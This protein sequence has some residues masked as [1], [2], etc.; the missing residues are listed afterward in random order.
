MAGL[1]CIE[2]PV[3]TPMAATGGN[4]SGGSGSGGA[5]GG[6]VSGG[7]P[8]VAGSA[9]LCAGKPLPPSPLSLLTRGQYE[10]TIF[11][12]LTD[13]SKPAS[14][15]PPENQVQGFKN[16]TTAHQASPLAVEKYLEAAERL[17]TKAVATRL[18]ELAPC[19][20]GD[21]M[22]CG[23][24][25]VRGFGLKAFRRPLTQSEAQLFDDL[26]SRTLAQAGYS[27]AVQL[28]L[29]VFL[30]SPQFLYRVDSRRAPTAE[31]GALPLAPY[32]LASRLSYF[33]TGSM[34]DAQLFAAAEANQLQTDAEVETQTRRM[35]ELPRAR[36]VVREF[37]H[38]WL[39][40]DALPSIAREA[41]DL[42]ADTS[43][44]GK[45]WLASLD[46]F[47]DHVYWESGNVAALFDSKRVYLNGRLGALYGASVTGEDFVSVEQ[48]ERAGI[49]TQPGLLALLAHGDQSA[50]VL[51]G[52]FVLKRM[53]CVNVPAPPPSVNNTPPDPNPNSTTR[54]RFRVHTESPDCAG[55][56]RMI[57]GV[58]FGFE[59]FDQLGRYRSLENGLPVDTKGEVLA[60]DP[61][62]DGAFNG[63]L[64]LA[65]RLAQSARVRDCMA[66]SWYRFA[67]GRL[68]SE[69]D[70]CSL[71]EV[72][73]HFAKASGDLRELLVSITKSVAFRY[74]PAIGGP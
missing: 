24:A 34:P 59:G 33:L 56:H 30:Q 29:Q 22:S 20:A 39:E 13:D 54:E 55:C 10:N 52:V 44:F 6:T 51:R 41:T 62:L 66:A 3:G 36:A 31:T 71:N 70:Q 73:S 49:V 60:G 57:D 37:H 45:D 68:E 72:K 32:E 27:A 9:P 5:S 53:M 69:A 18:T 46:R 35:L 23:R 4:G 67:L 42:V 28:A 1:G 48:P 58:G 11:D 47:V 64:E 50:P 25:F 63:T 43:L 40:L 19:S 16:N 12:L 2:Q 65:S 15:F 61:A 8:N 7:N 38:Q 17:S 26:F 14:D 74:R 21:N